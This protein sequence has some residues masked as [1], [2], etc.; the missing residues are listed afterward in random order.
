MAQVWDV[1]RYLGRFAG[2]GAV[3]LDSDLDFNDALVGINGRY[4]FGNEK[5]WSLH[6]YA[7]IG[8]GE[9][10]FTWQTVLGLGY[11]F[12]WGELFFNYRH[13][14][15]ELGDFDRFNDLQLT[16]SGPSMGA[17]VRF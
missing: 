1:T 11:T 13:L 12:G 5:R 7:D 6:Y 3:A 14:D 16:F 15:Y 4:G 10:D 8:T 17:T 2:R 9:S